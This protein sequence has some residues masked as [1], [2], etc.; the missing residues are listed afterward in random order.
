[1]RKVVIDENL[2]RVFGQIFQQNG[3]EPLDV[4]DHELRGAP[5]SAVFDFA[6]ERRAAVA[7]ADVGFAQRIHRLE[8]HNGIFFLR[9]L[10]GLI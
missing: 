2:P 7:T 3:I 4:R 6:R 1:M 9:F 10:L 5:D 8:N